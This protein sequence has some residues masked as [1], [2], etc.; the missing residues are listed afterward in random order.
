MVDCKI[1]SLWGAVQVSRVQI[2]PQVEAVI[3]VVEGLGNPKV[4]T[5]HSPM[6]SLEHCLPQSPWP[7]HLPLDFACHCLLLSTLQSCQLQ[8]PPGPLRLLVVPATPPL[9]AARGVC[10]HLLLEAMESHHLSCWNPLASSD[11]QDTTR[12]RGGAGHVMTEWALHIRGHVC[13]W[14]QAFNVIGQW[15]QQFTWLASSIIKLRTQQCRCH[16]ISQQSSHSPN[17]SPT[18]TPVLRAKRAKASFESSVTLCPCHL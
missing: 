13:P 17:Q 7:H 3:E 14:G 11:G 8:S 4:S 2:L 15:P 5:T 6:K 12:E 9:V 16:A 18:V 10:C 1:N